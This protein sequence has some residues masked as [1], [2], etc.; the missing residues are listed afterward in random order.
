MNLHI[1]EDSL[2]KEVQEEFNRV[3][4]FLKIEFFD[5]AHGYRQPSAGNFRFDPKQ[6][7]M[8]AG[9]K[10]FRKGDIE[11]GDKM[12]VYEL[13]K[14]LQDLF[15]LSA[16]VM[17]KSGNIWLET[18]MTDNWTLKEQNEHGKEISGF[19]PR[20]GFEPDGVGY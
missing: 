17:R 2:I 9:K 11:L 16:Q 5:K 20:N 7:I 12:T 8:E 15:C 1:S 3:Y 18:T 19:D 4:P 6:R 10:G 14:K 13:E